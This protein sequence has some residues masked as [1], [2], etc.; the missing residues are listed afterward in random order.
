M[1]DTAPPKPHLPA[2]VGPL[3]VDGSSIG[4]CSRMK[5][6]PPPGRKKSAKTA[7]A[8]KQVES[9]APISLECN[10]STALL[11]VLNDFF[12]NFSYRTQNNPLEKD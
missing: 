10:W 8:L 5:M 11:N 3:H 9:L 4:P 6:P 7:A 1:A 12:Y 2:W